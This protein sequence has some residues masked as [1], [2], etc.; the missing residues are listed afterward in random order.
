[1]A[2]IICN[3]L[4]N[5]ITIVQTCPISH[6]VKSSQ[7]HGFD[8][9]EVLNFW[10]IFAFF[11]AFL[12]FFEGNNIRRNFVFFIGIFLFLMGDFI[13]FFTKLGYSILHVLL[14]KE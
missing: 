5:P 13:D 7:S 9:I 2:G 4:R 12:H 8:W 10:K 11:G 3:F 6:K 14:T 1:M